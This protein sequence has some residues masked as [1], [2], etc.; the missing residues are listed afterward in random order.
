MRIFSS[1][2]RYFVD[3]HPNVLRGIL[4]T[5]HFRTLI[6]IAKQATNCTYSKS[7]TVSKVKAIHV[8]VVLYVDV[9]LD[10]VWMYAMPCRKMSA[11][12]S[13]GRT[14]GIAVVSIDSDANVGIMFHIPSRDS[15][16]Q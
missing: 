14:V 4:R 9:V 13:L 10:V 6:G 16:I 5:G 8:L 15:S 1:F 12:L 7:S 2:G 11:L 3:R